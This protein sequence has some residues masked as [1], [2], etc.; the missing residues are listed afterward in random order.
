MD[1]VN[2]IFKKATFFIL[3]TI[4]LVLSYVPAQAT[5]DRPMCDT[6]TKIIQDI[7]EQHGETLK[8]TGVSY[9]GTLLEIFSNDQTGTFTIILTRDGSMGCIALN[10]DAY[11]KNDVASGEPA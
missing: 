8:L 3:A 5:H 2:N 7:A 9:S 1:N 6:R 11:E 10:G 4:A